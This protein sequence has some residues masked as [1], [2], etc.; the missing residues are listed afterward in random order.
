[1]IRMSDILKLLGIGLVLVFLGVITKGP[2]KSIYDFFANLFGKGANPAPPAVTQHDQPNP[3]DVS[4]PHRDDPAPS[5]EAR[6]RYR[7]DLAPVIR[8]QAKYYIQQAYLSPAGINENEAEMAKTLESLHDVDQVI[9]FVQ[10][11]NDLMNAGFWKNHLAFIAPG[12]NK[13]SFAESIKR[14]D[15][16]YDEFCVRFK[17]LY[18]QAL[19]EMS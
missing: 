8:E 16:T 13:M 14:M 15:S 2:I 9:V 12:V 18:K 5:L 4:S 11:Y 6:V 7:I 17:Q 1:M 10:Q 3:A 19:Q